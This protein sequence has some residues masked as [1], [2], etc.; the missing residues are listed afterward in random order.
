[1]G[2]L[3]QAIGLQPEFRRSSQRKTPHMSTAREIED[4]ARDLI[5]HQHDHPPVRDLNREVERRLTFADRVADDFARLVGSWV[6]VLVQAGIMVVWIGL[7]ALNLIRPWD[8]Y[9]FFF[10]NFILTLE[11]AVWVSVVLMAMNRLADRDRLRAQ[12]DY[13]LN[14]KAEEELKALM[15]HL[16]HIEQRDAGAQARRPGASADQYPG[17]VT[18]EPT[19]RGKPRTH[20]RR[21]RLC[22]AA[23]SRRDWRHAGSPAGRSSR[24]RC[25]TYA[26]DPGPQGRPGESCCR[27]LSSGRSRRAHTSTAS[28]DSR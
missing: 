6:F 14:V 17:A 10:L 12:H 13:E 9:P 18:A 4:I 7:N 1:M 24:S 25:R 20:R 16:M 22:R 27:R 19:A 3:R 8:R 5:K 23:P 2:L 28:L 15:N 26:R 21:R 11:A